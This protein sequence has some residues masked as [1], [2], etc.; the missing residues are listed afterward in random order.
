MLDFMQNEVYNWFILKHR[1]TKAPHK[2]ERR[3]VK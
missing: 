3:K 1:G 2:K